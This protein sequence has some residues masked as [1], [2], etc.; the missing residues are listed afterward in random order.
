VRKA[1]GDVVSDAVARSGGDDE[2]PA[3]AP[4]TG[5]NLKAHIAELELRMQQAAIDLE[6]EEAARLRDEIRRLEGDD[7]ETDGAQARPAGRADA[8]RPGTRT[9]K[10]TKMRAR[11]GR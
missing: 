8:G 11:R 9:N 6:F 3:D 2:T 5:H 7:A 4:R 1:V 10:W